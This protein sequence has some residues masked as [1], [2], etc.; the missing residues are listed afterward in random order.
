MTYV[1]DGFSLNDAPLIMETTQFYDYINADTGASL[2]ISIDMADDVAK[3][4]DAENAEYKQNP[5]SFVSE[6]DGYV[7]LVVQKGSNIIEVVGQIPKEE[8]VK[9]VKGVK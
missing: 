3:G 5:T 4:V 6:K 1:P 2:S 8:A 9:I 7:I